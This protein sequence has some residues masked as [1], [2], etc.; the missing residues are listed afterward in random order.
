MSFLRTETLHPHFQQKKLHV[1]AALKRVYRNPS[2]SSQAQPGHNRRDSL[3]RFTRG[4][5]PR[6]GAWAFPKPPG[7]VRKARGTGGMSFVLGVVV[8]GR[9]RV[10]VSELSLDDDELSDYQL[11]LKENFASIVGSCIY[12]SITCRPDLSTIVSKACKGMHGPKKI[13]MASC[14]KRRQSSKLRRTSNSS[15]TK[16][17]GNGGRFNQLSDRTVV[18]V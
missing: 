4:L 16:S 5:T 3:C 10:P 12:F 14:A 2:R 1:A 17:L 18:T 6:P 13:H 7:G 11:K 8:A 9:G 15:L